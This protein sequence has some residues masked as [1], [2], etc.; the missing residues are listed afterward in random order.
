MNNDTFFW[1]MCFHHLPKLHRTFQCAL[2]LVGLVTMVGLRVVDLRLA[3]MVTRSL[4]N[5]EMA[6]SHLGHR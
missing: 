1:F 4:G 6:V 5:G 2:E 3:L